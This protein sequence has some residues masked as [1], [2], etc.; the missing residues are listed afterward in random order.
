MN[1]MIRLAKQ[2]RSIYDLMSE[3]SISDEQLETILKDAVMHTPSAFNSQTSRVLLLL[4]ED[5]LHFWDLV[6][7][8]LKPMVP[9]HRLN[10][11]KEKI[12]SFKAG[13]GTIL[14]FEEQTTIL[15]LQNRFKLY[16]EQF[17]IWS[18]Q[19]AGMLQYVVWTALEEEG[20]GASLQHYNPII[21]DV[22]Q[23][24]WSV[25]KAWHLV[26]QMPFGNIKAPAKE[27]SFL[28]IEERFFVGKVSQQ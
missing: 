24:M 28:P 25:P 5:H 17:P 16:A 27:K 19:A 12:E 22:V 1:N 13:Y 14:F 4:K 11:T 8:Q 2:R 20:I 3:I 15:D 9:E 18:M 10:S 26:A 7:D 23:T 21:D 6:F